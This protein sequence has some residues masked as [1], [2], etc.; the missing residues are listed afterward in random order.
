M[1]EN[2]TWKVGEN[3]YV[4]IVEV[5]PATAYQNE[6]LNLTESKTEYTAKV[7]LMYASDYKFAAAPSAWTTTLNKYNSSSITSVNWMYMGLNEWT[8]TRQSN[9]NYIVFYLN[10]GGNLSFNNTDGVFAI[11][12]TFYILPSVTYSSGTGTQSNPIRL[13]V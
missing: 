4:N 10:D 8:I 13:E 3:T 1:I 7:G 12:P 9:E 6:I 2:T 5:V 11:R